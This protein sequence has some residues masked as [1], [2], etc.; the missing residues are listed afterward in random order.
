[1]MERAIF[2]QILQMDPLSG[3]PF[4][5]KDLYRLI[6]K[7]AELNPACEWRFTTNGHWRLSSYIQ[8]Q[9]DRLRIRFISVSVDSLSPANYARL[10]KGSLERV[11]RTVE[12]LSAYRS[13]RVS[14]GLGT[15]DLIINCTIFNENW[16][17]LP[18]LIEYPLQKGLLPFVQVLYRPEEFSVLSS[19]EAERIKILEFC[20]KTLSKDQ[21]RHAHRL[22]RALSDTFNG[23]MREKFLNLLQAALKAN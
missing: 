12:D 14:R 15:F 23:M 3:E 4:I 11:L 19:P 5:Q 9:L 17:E 6:D 1:M 20:F 22:I 18:E 16:R 10:R 21:F 2:P 13:E 7:M 8:G